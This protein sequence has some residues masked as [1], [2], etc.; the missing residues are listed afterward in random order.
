M[1]TRISGL[2]SG[3]DID[4]MVKSMLQ[5]DR[6]KVDKVKQNK[7][8]LEWKQQLYN[9]INKEFAEFIVNAKK[10]FGLMTSKLSGIGWHKQATSNNED[11]VTANVSGINSFS[12]THDIV[13]KKMA[14]GVSLQS[15]GA[16]AM[17]DWTAED[18]TNLAE[19]GSF[20]FAINGKNIEVLSTDN[21]SSVARKINSAGA[22]VKA[23]Y[24]STLDIFFLQSDT[25]GVSAK[26]QITGA[27]TENGEVEALGAASAEF[28]EKLKI[29]FN[30]ISPNLAKRTSSNSMKDWKATGDFAIEID[31]GE[32]IQILEGDD[33]KTVA[34][35]ITKANISGLSATYTE[36]EDGDLF[37][38]IIG[39]GNL[40]ISFENSEVEGAIDFKSKLGID[41]DGYIGAKTGIGFS[42]E[43]S[44][45]TVYYNGIESEIKN[46][47]F[48]FNGV[49]FTAKSE[50]KFIGADP[51]DP[52]DYIK[53]SVSITPNID[54]AIEKITKF[55][56]E[57]NK[58]LD[59]AGSL[60]GEKANRNYQPLT[61]EQ[62]EAMT[63]KEIELWE[64]R[65][66]KGLLSRDSS[67][68]NMLSTARSGLY[69]SV[70]GYNSTSNDYTDNITGT[71]SHI[72]EIGITTQEYASGTVG[73]K[74][75]INETKLREALANDADSVLTMLFKEPNSD[76]TK[77]LDDLG[78][79]EGNE[80]TKKE[81]EMK[82]SE[83]GLFTRLVEDMSV[84]MKEIISKSGAGESS[85]LFRDVKYN[86]LLEFATGKQGGVSTIQKQMND[87][88][89]QIDDLNVWLFNREN[90]YY[91]RFTAM[92]KAMQNAN[93]QSSWLYQQMGM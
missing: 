52:A 59:K 93:N 50:S 32:S 67:I 16:L 24:D 29:G 49:T 87:M 41:V 11:A 14:E 53:T 84:G 78:L 66:K 18:L 27:V 36:E 73:G 85:Q 22:G 70:K 90:S 25:V 56:D 19:G 86:L 47:T 74:L 76:Y 64:E 60:I 75:K 2:A 35:K 89:K 42:D 82:R 88:S 45:G 38:S 39:K 26:V 83:S 77:T 31:S 17:K 72:T 51:N 20:K 1:V 65:A 71:Y 81:A 44:S 30:P 9:D 23:S 28:I 37:L 40:K 7:Q 5:V 54:T 15:S 61:D 92:E 6:I 79:A 8:S 69:Q 55:V 62:K 12:G 48:T 34:S 43:G 33:I 13:V 46:N 57:Y 3:M 10:E 80:R 58:M 4:S 91:S 68:A 63:E 21:L